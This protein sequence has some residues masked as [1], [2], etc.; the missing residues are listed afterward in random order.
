MVLLHRY[1]M[2]SS[3]RDD[4]RYR[5]T[6]YRVTL[7]FPDGHRFSEL[8]SDTCTGYWYLYDL[9]FPILP[10]DCRALP[11]SS[12]GGGAL[13]LTAAARGEHLLPMV[14]KFNRIRTGRR[15]S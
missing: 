2:I 15:V 12:S 8:F 10:L 7:F 4:T 1:G 14:A 9:V 5:R 6:L 3:A 13:M 11:S